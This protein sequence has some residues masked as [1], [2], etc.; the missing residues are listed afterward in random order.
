MPGGPTIRHTIQPGES[1]DVIARRYSVTRQ[2]LFE[3]NPR[4]MKAFDNRGRLD[5]D[6]EH[7]QPGTVVRVPFIAEPPIVEEPAAPEAVTWD[8]SRPAR[9]G[10][11]LEY[12]T[13]LLDQTIHW[14]RAYGEPDWVEVIRGI[15]LPKSVGSGDLAHGFLRHFPTPEAMC[16]I[17]DANPSRPRGALP[18]I[19]YESPFDVQRAWTLNVRFVRWVLWGRGPMSQDAGLQSIG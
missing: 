1:S 18:G 11:L 10:S 15:P 19:Q 7:F 14:H 16:Q 13:H 17:L 5:F 4:L 2:E 3:L 12:W 9:G 8:G 6:P